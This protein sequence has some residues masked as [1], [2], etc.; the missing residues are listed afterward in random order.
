MC[1]CC[2]KESTAFFDSIASKWDSWEDLATLPAKLDAELARF[3]IQPDDHVLDVGCGTGN[4]TAAILRQVSAQGKV[5]AIDMSDRMIAIAQSKIRD[6][7]V[8]WLCD[9]V[10]HLDNDT[11]PFDRIIC[12]SV[13]PHLTN[14]RKAAAV[15][16]NLLKPGGALDIWHLISRDAVNKIHSEASEAVRDHILQPAAKTGDLLAQ[17]GFIVDKMVDSD[18]RYLVSARKPLS[19]TQS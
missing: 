18:T 17:T 16:L 12:Y 4:L 2:Q 1:E 15:F 13:W 11:G 9:A 7:R 19:K 5:T 14:P 3:G 8:T 6:P 10:E